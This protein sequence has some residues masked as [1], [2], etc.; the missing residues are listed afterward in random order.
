[1]VENAIVMSLLINFENTSWSICFS[2]ITKKKVLYMIPIHA[3]NTI[4]IVGEIE[5]LY[6]NEDILAEDG[7]INLSKGKIATINGLDGYAVPQLYNRFEYQRP[8]DIQ[9]IRSTNAP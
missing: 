7:F 3:N 6:V 8:K 1:M 4:L 2:C 5:T 9:H